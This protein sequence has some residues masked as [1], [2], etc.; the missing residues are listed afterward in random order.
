MSILVKNNITFVMSLLPPHLRVVKRNWR[1]CFV[2][3][4]IN[5]IHMLP[6]CCVH[7]DMA[8]WGCECC[9]C[10]SCYTKYRLDWLS[11]NANEFGYTVYEFKSCISKTA[12]QHN[13]STDRHGMTRKHTE[14]ETVL[15]T[16]SSVQDKSLMKT[17]CS[18]KR[19]ETSSQKEA[20]AMD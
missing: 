8:L 17:L 9:K 19:R 14:N 15:C 16:Y 20:D 13:V 11:C 5:S 7:R 6:Y 2:T 3:A 10:M 12:A 4:P 18:E 1:I